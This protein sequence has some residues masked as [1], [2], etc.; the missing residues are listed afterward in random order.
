MTLQEIFD[1]T[2]N[3]LLDGELDELSN[4]IDFLDEAQQ[5]IA[6]IDMVPATPVEY[7]LTTNAITL[8]AD[9]LRL[10]K[11]TLEEEP[12][13]FTDEPWAGE[14]TLPTGVTEG[15]LKLWYFK[16]PAALSVLTPTQV[17]EVNPV[18]H[19]MMADYAAKMYY[20]IDDDAD[21]RDAFAAEFRGKIASFKTP[22][23]VSSGRF[24]NY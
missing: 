19:R 17:P 5:M 20:L 23:V 1:Y 3:V 8:P 24:K 21:M 13:T 22:P 18:Y 14:L 6:R 7:E 9:F 2:N 11:A 10:Y 15:T 16:I 4:I 12:Y